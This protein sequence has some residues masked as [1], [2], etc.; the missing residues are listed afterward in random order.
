MAVVD[1]I[2]GEVYGVNSYV[3]KGY[4]T[5]QVLGESIYI[6][7]SAGGSVYELNGTL[8]VEAQWTVLGTDWNWFVGA[9][10]Q[11]YMGEYEVLRRHDLQSRTN[12]TMLEDCIFH[13]Y[14]FD[15]G[16]VS[17]TYKLSPDGE[18]VHGILDLNRNE[19][20]VPPVDLPMTSC[21]KTGDVWLGRLE[22]N[23]NI[24]YLGNSQAQYRIRT[25]NET[26]SLLQ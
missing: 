18:Y 20:W 24:Y 15:H 7:D 23:E 19:L 8:S 12:S 2:T 3:L 13:I 1:P 11:L 16:Q 6:C 22:N 26:I 14:A 10:R 17:I 5:P 4:T 9:D 21:R 25:E